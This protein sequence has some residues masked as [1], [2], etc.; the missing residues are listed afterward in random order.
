MARRSLLRPSG[1]WSKFC[2]LLAK[3][4]S[5][6]FKFPLEPVWHPLASTGLPMSD[7]SPPSPLPP[8]L[9]WLQSSFRLR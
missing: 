6:T 7:V 1:F 9:T 8:A 3:C 4:S 2:P 5:D